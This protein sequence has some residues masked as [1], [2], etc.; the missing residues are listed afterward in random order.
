M[1]IFLSPHFDDAIGSTGGIIS[2][3]LN[4][5]KQV[6]IITI[7]GGVPENPIDKEYVL[8]RQQ[9]NLEACRLLGVSYAN[10]DFLDAIYRTE[11]DYS[12]M[13][14]IFNQNVILEKKL[15]D[16]ICKYLNKLLSADDIVVAPTSLGNHI[17]HKIVKTVAEKLRQK[18]IFYEDF[19]YDTITKD[20]NCI[21][22]YQSLELTDAELQ[23]KLSA[24]E[25]YN[26]QIKDLFG[27]KEKMLN[28]FKFFHTANNRPVE[29]FN[30][31]SVFN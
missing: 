1:Y 5:S 19:F 18:T 17:D 6:K 16:E 28:Y 20:Y 3:L 14:S 30:D 31:I 8:R 23:I 13:N 15:C 2:R 11:V 24:I 9:E 10:A 27:T 25:K 21:K 26:S 4:K 12:A 29:R 22:N 7:M